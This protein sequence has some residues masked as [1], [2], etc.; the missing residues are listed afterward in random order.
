MWMLLFATLLANRENF[1]KII[2]VGTSEI[3][4]PGGEGDTLTSDDENALVGF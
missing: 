3:K 1:K 2:M 4:I